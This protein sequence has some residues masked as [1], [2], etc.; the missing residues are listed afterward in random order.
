MVRSWGPPVCSDV[1]CEL[2][3]AL[4]RFRKGSG[5]TGNIKKKR[6]PSPDSAERNVANRDASRLRR[7]KEA[8]KIKSSVASW[9]RP[10]KLHLRAVHLQLTLYIIKFTCVGWFFFGGVLTCFT[11]LHFSFRLVKRFLFPPKKKPKQHFITCAFPTSNSRFGRKQ[12]GNTIHCVCSRDGSVCTDV[13]SLFTWDNG[14][15][16]LELCCW[17]MEEIIPRRRCC[18]F[19]FFSFL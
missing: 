14:S 13:P 8:K 19:D 12:T 1:I 6:V 5:T 7:N 4:I 11:H 18:S 10:I 17:T 16:Y 3:G 15:L 9:Q 2:W